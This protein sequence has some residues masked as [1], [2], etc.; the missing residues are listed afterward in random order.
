[1]EPIYLKLFFEDNVIKMLVDK[2][3]YCKMWSEI[4]LPFLLL[5]FVMVMITYFK[6]YDLKC[7]VHNVDWNFFHITEVMFHYY[8]LIRVTDLFIF[9]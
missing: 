8:S 1:M 7:P 2:I 6:F 9:L 4:Q 5:L 3:L